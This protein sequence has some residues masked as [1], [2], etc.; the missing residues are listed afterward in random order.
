MG[1]Y[2]AL[3]LC[4]STKSDDLESVNSLAL[5]HDNV[6]KLELALTKRLPPG[7]VSHVF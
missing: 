4:F 7:N 1:S 2:V 3:N 6:G 5:D